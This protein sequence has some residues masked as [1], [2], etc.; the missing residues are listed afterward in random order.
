MCESSALVVGDLGI[1]E[2]DGE[3]GDNVVI[4][5]GDQ[6]MLSNASYYPTWLTLGYMEAGRKK[7]QER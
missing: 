2:V 7:E 5:T 6:P 1:V 4:V 3:S